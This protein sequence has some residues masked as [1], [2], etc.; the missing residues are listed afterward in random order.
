M[1]HPTTTNLCVVKRIL[2]YLT[3]T[4]HQGIFITAATSFSISTYSD[5]DWAGCPATRRS[6]SGYRVLFSGNI[7]SWLKLCNLPRITM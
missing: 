7:V 5:G 2:K 4:I 1:H 6:I 3:R